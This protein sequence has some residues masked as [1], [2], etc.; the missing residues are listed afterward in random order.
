MKRRRGE[1]PSPLGRQVRLITAITI[2]GFICIN[3]SYRWGL[4]IGQSWLTIAS[5]WILVATGIIVRALAAIALG[6]TQKIEALVTSGIY[7]ETRNPIYLAMVLVMVGAALVSRAMLAIGWAAASMAALYWL[8][9]R[10]ERDLEQAFGETYRRYKQNVP[11]FWPHI[12]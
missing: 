2:L 5:G 9:K 12:R 4:V 6:S 1:T 7:G 11:M 3:G 8:A 10:E